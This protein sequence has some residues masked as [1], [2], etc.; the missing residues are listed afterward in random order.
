M[1]RQAEGPGGTPLARPRARATKS[2]PHLAPTHGRACLHPL[3]LDAFRVA[4][5]Q[6]DMNNVGYYY[7]QVLA[8]A[9]VVGSVA[10]ALSGFMAGARKRLDVMGV[11]ILAFLTANGGGVVRD[12]L[13]GRTP[14]IMRGMSPFWIAV[15]VVALALLFRLQLRDFVERHRIF[16]VSDAVGL[17]AFG[18]T[19]ALVGIEEGL[20]LFGVVTLSFLTATGGGIARDVLANE[21]PLVLREDFYGSVALLLGVAVYMLHAAGW[22]SPISLTLLFVA[23]LVLRLVAHSRGWKLPKVG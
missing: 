9:S 18:I 13:I 15:G 5:E 10:F 3:G 22:T 12:L 8:T 16:L 14:A 11:F 21:V 17:V 1:I 23:G 4:T 7:T 2:R 20:H 19:G 6:V